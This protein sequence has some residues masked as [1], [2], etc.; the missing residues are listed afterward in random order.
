MCRG[1]RG[2]PRP[3]VLKHYLTQ[4]LRSFWRFRVTALVNLI[5][6]SL[7]LVCFIAT[8]LF[9]DGLLRNGDL[10]FKRADRIY[11]LT[12]EL[13]STPNSRMIPAFPLVA[14]GT[15][16]YLKADLP[17]L[18]AVARAAGVG[19][20]AVASDDRSAYVPAAAV[21]PEFLN[22][23]DFPLLSGA[24]QDALASTHNVVLTKN[25]AMRLFG[26]TNVVGRA[27][28]LQNRTQVS[29]VAV[30]GEAPVGSHLGGPEGVQLRFEMLFPMKLA[31]ELS[32]SSPVGLMNPDDP[33][34][35]NDGYWTYVLLPADGSVTLPQLKDTL[36]T[37]ADRH[38]PKD[39]MLSVFDAVPL[40]KARLAMMEA[41]SNNHSISLTI[42]PF[43]LDI[44]ILAIACLNYAN[45]SVAI[46]TTRAREI[47]MRK[48]L[49][50]S[51]R[52]LLRQH[53]LEAALLGT[54]ALI[55][56]LIGTLIA[57]PTLN[58][59]LD[60]QFQLSSLRQPG[61]WGLVVVLLAFI[62]LVGG[63]Y[64]A[65]VLGRVR[66]VD[67]LRAAA[68]STGPRFVPTILVGIQFAA[69]SFLLVVTLLM[70]TQ[71]KLLESTALHP[72]QDPVVA[73]G[74]DIRQFGV[75]FDSL[76]A[77]LLR[78]PRIK[79]VSGS[80]NLIWQNGGP[81]QHL[82]RAHDSAAVTVSMMNTV[83]YG[84]FDTLGLEI[85]AGRDFD[86][87]RGDVKFEWDPP[88]GAAPTTVIVD[89]ALATSL[90]FKNAEDAVDQTIYLTYPWTAVPMPDRPIHVVGVVENGYPRLVGPTANSNMY[91]LSALGTTIPLVRI[92]RDDIPGA[93][94]HIDA[95][96]KKLVPKAP[97][98]RYFADDLFSEAYRNFSMVSAAL[99]GLCGFA[100]V[101]A[102]MG[103]VGMAVHITSRRRRE[104]GIRK[105]LGASARGVVFMLLRDFSKP[106]LIANVVA[107]PF[108]YLGGQLYFNLFTQQAAMSVWPF[109]IGLVITV[110][111]AWLAVSAQAFRAA[112]VKPASVLHAD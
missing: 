48:V 45:L 78:D 59:M 85:L 58:R 76:R 28:V 25:G 4:A 51:Q 23:F 10:K 103:L 14:P 83:T 71:N 50:A 19:D 67:A 60:L 2:S 56:V 31:F 18:E 68:V 30:I 77:E 27:L 20:V 61:L 65:L 94:A 35:G 70:A 104:I 111:V 16:S 87:T 63:A 7:A 72:D 88:A 107:W 62:S 89:R 79:A 97:A 52:H 37:F 69:A 81:H 38:V 9:V 109:V 22:I 43:L 15:A 57:V 80:S 93:L 112:A 1:L 24:L 41:L 102:V 99:T 106:V 75:E 46:A 98:R 36:R 44:L 29:V 74:N 13:W 95:V 91:V 6:L 73:I 49:G 40:H 90:G 110:A 108:A 34:W 54:V 100:F 84:M 101:I 64:P 3:P 8:Y 66:P 11:A 12:Q 26:T 39:Q 96:W 42:S 55:L 32:G 53:L 21:D 17:K 47:G 86:R 92:A 33:Q 105:T 82:R 5:G